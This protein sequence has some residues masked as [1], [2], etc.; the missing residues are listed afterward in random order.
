MKKLLIPLLMLSSFSY[1]ADY[2]IFNRNDIPN[3]TILTKKIPYNLSFEQEKQLVL[4]MISWQK[5]NFPVIYKCIDELSPINKNEHEQEYMMGHDISNCYQKQY[6][7]LSK[8]FDNS[9]FINSR[10]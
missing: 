6:K 4:E 7:T 2:S 1:A 5:N 9:N 3:K 10:H 8:M